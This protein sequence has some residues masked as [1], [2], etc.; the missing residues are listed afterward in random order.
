MN[1]S[2][3][4]CDAPA[5][6]E[7]HVV[8]QS[9]GGTRTVPLCGSCHAK[10]HGNH[11]LAH[12]RS[13]TKAALAVKASRGERTGQVPYG[14]RLAADG[15]HLEADP[16]EQRAIALVAQ[17]QSEG[18]SLRAIGARLEAA[19]CVP[20]G[21]ARW[22]PDTVARIDARSKAGARFDAETSW[23]L[24]TIARIAKRAKRGGS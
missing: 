15:V 9:I 12:T 11:G 14:S 24:T 20:R 1:A 13:L 21:G 3:F 16:E 19:G 2:C 22:H 6:A 17:Y 7:H 18:I 8:P 23:H 4:E 10:V 5:D